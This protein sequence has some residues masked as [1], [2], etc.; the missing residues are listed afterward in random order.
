MSVEIFY[1]NS[2]VNIFIINIHNEPIKMI[3]NFQSFSQVM[4][5]RASSKDNASPK[6]ITFSG[7]E[8]V[9][10]KEVSLVGSPSLLFPF[11]EHHVTLK[12]DKKCFILISLHF[13]IEMHFLHVYPSLEIFPFDTSHKDSNEVNSAVSCLRY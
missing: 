5:H 10:V 3:A 6:I 7:P 2:Q 13:L 11:L 12:I 4:T 9:L 1:L 8:K